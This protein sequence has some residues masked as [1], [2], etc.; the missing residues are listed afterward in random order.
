[1]VDIDSRAGMDEGADDASLV[2]LF[3]TVNRELKRRLR[4]LLG[5]SADADE[6][7]QE[8]WL[9][10]WSHRDK[11]QENA[12]GYLFIIARNLASKRRASRANKPMLELEACESEHPP[13]LLTPE[14]F[15]ASRQELDFVQREFFNLSPVHQHVVLASLEGQGQMDIAD[16]LGISQATVSRHLQKAMKILRNAQENGVT[17]PMLPGETQSEGAESSGDEAAAG[18][19]QNKLHKNRL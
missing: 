17:L 8:A 1:M 14:H 3:A 5:N 15:L 2:R 19:S 11:I 7:A 16:E 18:F 6:V 10:V 13:D 12:E 4:S 9:A